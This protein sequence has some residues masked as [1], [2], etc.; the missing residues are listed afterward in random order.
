[1]AR[2]PLAE[3]YPPF[4]AAIGE[5]RR[6]AAGEQLQVRVERLPQGEWRPGPEHAEGIGLLIIDGLLMRDVT[7]AD[8]IATEIVGRG[9]VLRPSEH[10][11]ADAPVPFDIEWRVLQPTTIALLDRSFG[12]ALARWPEVVEAIVASAVRRSLSLALHLAV[13]H[14]RRV[15]ARL[16]VML[17]HMAD[18]WGKVTPD[19]V[20]VPLKLSHRMLGQLVGAQRPSVTT[21]LR[22]LVRDGSVT[23][24]GD[25]TWL[26]Q[27]DPPETF[28]RLRAA[29]AAERTSAHAG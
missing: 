11:G 12:T 1:M 19:G 26:L 10:D 7:L 20:I 5:D 23:R 16:L 13:L 15:D 21:A 2:A 18:R 14:L 27:G 6:A 24:R 4:L 29:T 8:T 22:D 3:I 28:A 17:W 9:D 25:G